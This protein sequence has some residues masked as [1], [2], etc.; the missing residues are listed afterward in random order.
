M[1]KKEIKTL[2][3]N[4]LGQINQL[5][6]A[7]ESCNLIDDSVQKKISN[8]IFA[9]KGQI[10]SLIAPKVKLNNE[11]VNTNQPTKLAK[12][13]EYNKTVTLTNTN[14]LEKLKKTSK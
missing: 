3:T 1:T 2:E 13:N 10:K 11:N 5:S 6:Q 12:A 8:Y 9:F 4:T 7:L 14:V